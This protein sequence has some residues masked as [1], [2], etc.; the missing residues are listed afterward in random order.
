MPKIQAKQFPRDIVVKAI[1][2][3]VKWQSYSESSPTGAGN[4]IDDAEGDTGDNIIFTI[5]TE[6][7]YLFCVCLLT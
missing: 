1:D 4:N 6:F 2:L 3:W 5:L 7:C